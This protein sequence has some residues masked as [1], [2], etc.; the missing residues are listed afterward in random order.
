MFPTSPEAR[1]FK[2]GPDKLM[3]VVNHGLYPYF[4]DLLKEDLL[5][6]PFLVILF[7]ESLN[8][9]LQKSEMDFFM[10]TTCNTSTGQIVQISMEKTQAM[11]RGPKRKGKD[12]SEERTIRT[13]GQ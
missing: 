1:D 5:Q 2:M 10:H 11:P 9:I 6:S 3:Y 12:G 8:D 4:K 13:A 7:N